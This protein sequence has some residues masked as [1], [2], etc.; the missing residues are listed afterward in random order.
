LSAIE[1]I[2]TGDGSHSLLNKEM[3]ETYHS[4][5]GAV[6]ESQYVFINKGLQYW[7]DQNKKSSVKIFEV[8]F[9]TGLNAF[10]TLLYNADIKIEYTTLEAFPLEENIWLGLNYATDEKKSL[11]ETIHG[12]EWNHSSKINA[13]FNIHKIKNT[14]QAIN[15]PSENYDLVFF[16][17]F[18]PNKQPEMWTL[19]M[20]EKIYNSMTGKGVFVTYCAKGQLKRDLKSLGFTVE[21]LPGPPGKKEMVRASKN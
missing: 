18:A 16:D 8:G 12:I 6:Q 19:Y 14:L 20:L 5:H 2:I 11:F 15:L 10:L 13:N 3:N 4:V 1:I 17:A 9:G 7:L 21:T